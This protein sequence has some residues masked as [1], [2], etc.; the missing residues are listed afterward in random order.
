MSFISTV[1]YRHLR[2]PTSKSFTSFASMLSVIGL[3]IGIAALIITMSILNG[4]E[5][6]L[7]KKLVSFDGHIQIQHILGYS[8]PEN[9]DSL[10]QYLN[11]HSTDL[12][13]VSY[14]RK[15][16]IVRKGQR[17]HSVLLEGIPENDA[18]YKMG[19]LVKFGSS[20]L[21]NNQCLLGKRLADELDVT[22]GDEI[23]FTQMG[24][25]T[26]K[27]NGS[28]INTREEEFI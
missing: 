20:H 18:S 2:S 13:A 12:R 4:F 3:A 7:S 23:V 10:S 21:G 11:S 26:S 22:V 25:Y 6:T 14:V 16:V 15:P 24:A 27:I 8:I 17:I 19:Q 28:Q 1:S 9:Q 5:K